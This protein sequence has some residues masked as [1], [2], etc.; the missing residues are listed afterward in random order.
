MSQQSFGFDTTF[1]FLGEEFLL[2]LWFKWETEGGEFTLHGGRIVGIAIDDM[3][4]FAPKSADEHQQTI[5]RGLPTRT[6]E[7]RTGLRQGHRLAKAR[8]ILAEGARQWTFTLDAEHMVLSGVKLPDDAE[9]CESAEDRTADRASNWLAIHEVL[10]ELYALFL[11][12]RA[13]TA[14]NE[15][16]ESM[17]A[18]MAR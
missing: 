7:A 17:A 13:T 15:E 6:A 3:L 11:R 8:M 9:E 12:V 10:G 18:W 14:W 2:W 5:R 4:A 1:G 16:A